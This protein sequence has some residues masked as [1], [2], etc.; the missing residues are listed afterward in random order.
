MSDAL[1]DVRTW[2]SAVATTV[3]GSRET[4]FCSFLSSLSFLLQPI[5]R[6]CVFVV[7]L[8]LYVILAVSYSEKISQHY[9]GK[10]AVPDVVLP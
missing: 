3:Q 10:T 5:D 6:I 4:S 8:S 2:S 1:V 9:I 7:L